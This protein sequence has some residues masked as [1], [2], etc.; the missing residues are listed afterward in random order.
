MK[1]FLL[2]APAVAGFVPLVLGLIQSLKRK[3]AI[4]GLFGSGWSEKSFQ[5]QADLELQAFGVSGGRSLGFTVQ[6]IEFS[7][8]D[9]LFLH[10]VIATSIAALLLTYSFY[11]LASQGK[12]L[13]HNRELSHEVE[14]AEQDLFQEIEDGLDE[15]AG[16][17][18]IPLNTC[19]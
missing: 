6:D 17:R 13:F 2:I 18:H 7:E 11:A 8:F 10:Y 19:R 3:Q 4:V 9:S 12:E 5:S 14:S 16:S 15:V 1:K